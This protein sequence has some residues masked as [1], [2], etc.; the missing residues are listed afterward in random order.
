M[1]NPKHELYTEQE[2]I[3]KLG[4]SR[5]RLYEL[6]DKHFFND[7][8]GRPKELTFTNSDLVLLG[9]W[10]DSEPNFKVL[11]MPQRR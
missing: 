4:I 7:G 3:A 10:Q 5:E 6:L 1:P 8:F 9:F 11:R 2:V